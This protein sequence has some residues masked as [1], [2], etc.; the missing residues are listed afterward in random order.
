MIFF[1]RKTEYALL[2]IEHMSLKSKEEEVITSTREIS[3]TYNIPHPLLSKVMQQLAGKGLMK[4][5]QGING[6]YVLAKKPSDISVMDVVEVFDGSF[7]LADCFK[8]EKITCPQ[9]NDCTIKSP[10]YELNHK[11][12]HLLAETTVADLS[13]PT[14]PPSFSTGRSPVPLPMLGRNKEHL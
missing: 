5:V 3:E 2:A 11:I 9:W 10:L 14:S 12:Y 1:N 13:K 4:S 7:A 6:G 8:N